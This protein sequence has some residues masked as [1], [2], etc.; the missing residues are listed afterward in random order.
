M[1]ILNPHGTNCPD[2]D[3]TNVSHRTCIFHDNTSSV[4]V[5]RPGGDQTIEPK[6]IT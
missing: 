4:A 5:N 3:W 6:S 2:G 1:N